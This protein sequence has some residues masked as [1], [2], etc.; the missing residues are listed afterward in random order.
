MIQSIDI[1]KLRNAEYIQFSRDFLTVVSLNNQAALKVVP[2]Y[3]AFEAVIQV[4]EGVFKTDQGSNITPLIEALDIRRDMAITGIFKNID[5][6][7]THFDEV[8]KAA[9]NVLMNHLKVY[10]N[11]TSIVTTA[12]PAETAVVNSM[13]ADFGTK[14]ELKAA[15]EL[16]GLNDWVAELQ[17]ANEQLSQKYIE[18]IVETGNANAN[19]IKDKRLEAN[20]LYYELRN[21]IVAQATVVKNA[22]PFPKALGELNAVVEQYNAILANRG[23]NKGDTP[24]PTEE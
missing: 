9:G 18:R 8:K 4:I 16:L 2:E 24:P 12:L 3:T 11:I 20:A 6:Y 22:P 21:M 15:L 13:V 10:G 14:A 1:A 5:S 19:V 23:G 17:S 7:T